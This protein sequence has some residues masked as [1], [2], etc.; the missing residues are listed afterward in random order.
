ML[1]NC[2]VKG[3]EICCAAFLSEDPVL[4]K[5]IQTGIDIH[6]VNQRDFNL[7]D[8]LTAKALVFRILYGGTE[9]AFA[10]DPEF[11]HV[12]KRID[13]WYNVIETFYDKYQ[14]LKNWHTKL[15]DNVILTGL[16]R[17]PT[18]REY[19][20]K[21]YVNKRG[22][23]TWPR[24]NILNY[25][26]QGFGADLMTIMRISLWNRIK[27]IKLKVNPIATV[28]D[29]I[30]LDTPKENVDQVVNIIRGVANDIPGN[31]LKVFGVKYRLPF[32]V[33]IEI[34]SNYLD[35]NKVN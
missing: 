13:F 34:G 23:L 7:P 24:T 4:T 6:S 14:G 19:T 8:R 2:D 18:G 5:E 15:V 32:E 28:H 25:P 35:L 26:V 16:Y 17:S 1:I 20:F 12:S 9:Y 10:N 31:F 27:K 11:T 22:E 21:P 29:S 3:L 33:E 30:L